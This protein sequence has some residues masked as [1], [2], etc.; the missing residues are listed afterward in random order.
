MPKST[1]PL[2]PTPQSSQVMAYGYDAA[3]KRLAVKFIS[4][5]ARMTYEYTDITPEFVAELDAAESKG[6]FVTKRLSR[7]KAPFDY[8]PEDPP[9]KETAAADAGDSEA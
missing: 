3:T 2:T 9:Q 8:C 4:N 5:G 1:I 6:A 7:A